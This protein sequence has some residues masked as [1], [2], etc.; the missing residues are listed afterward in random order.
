MGAA[1]LYLLVCGCSAGDGGNGFGSAASL[2][3]AETTEGS[4]GGGAEW[5]GTID[6]GGDATSDSATTASSQAGPADESAGDDEPPN[7]NET[8]NGLDDDGNGLVDDGLGT[9][10]CG[11]G[12]CENSAPACENGLPGVCTPLAASDEVCN[13]LDDNCD[14]SVDEDTTASC[15]SECGPGTETCVG[16]VPECDAPQ[17]QAETCNYQDDDCDGSL[18]ENVAGCRVGVHRA[19]NSSS[20][21]HFYTTNLMEASS[22]GFVVESQDYYDVYASAHAGLQGW[23]RCLKPN[24]KHFYTTSAGCE[25][26]TVEGVLGYVST[27]EAAESRALYRLFNGNLGDHFYTTSAAE[28]DTA[29]S[30]LGYVS[31]GVGCYVF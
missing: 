14:G 21:E 1:G 13:G 2:G 20:G 8:C 7:P 29:V 4:A 12:V 22:G 16:G 28:R 3:G 10:S 15:D 17:P 18:D 9:L 31:E 30:S 26:Q 19:H 23:Y 25:G 5:M 27:N 24:G 6:E 11:L